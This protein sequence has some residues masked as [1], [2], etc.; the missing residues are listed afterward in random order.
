MRLVSGQPGTGAFRLVQGEPGTGALKLVHGEPGTGALE[1]IELPKAAPLV[2]SAA[3]I[4]VRIVT[5]RLEEVPS[6]IIESPF[7]A[8]SWSNY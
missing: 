2:R 5:R 6:L 1:T 3:A 8:I 4:T 7:F